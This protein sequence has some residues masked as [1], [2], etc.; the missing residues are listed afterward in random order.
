MII[1]VTINNI[2]RDHITHLCKVYTAITEE[3]PIY[4][5]NPFDLEASFPQ[6]E[7]NESVLDWEPNTVAEIPFNEGNNEPFE[8][9]KFMYEEASF[10]VFGRSEETEPGIL[11]RLKKISKSNRVEIILLNK[12]SP[13]SKCATL[14]FLSKNNFDFTSLIFPKKHK[15]FWTDIDIL[16]TDDPKILK[17][18]PKGKISIK[19]HNDFNVDIKSDYVI[20][21]IKELNKVIKNIKKL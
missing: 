18:K 2:L 21:N 12:E 11:Q 8:I 7:G 6:K 14:F 20:F 19:Y 3:D 5:I 1:G 10:E 13:R 17:S 16:V 9:F 15:D 4:P